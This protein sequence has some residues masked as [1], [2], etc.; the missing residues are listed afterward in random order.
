MKGLSDIELLDAYAAR[1]SEEAFRELV[2]RHVDFTYAV[3][4]RL[5]RNPPCEGRGSKDL[6]TMRQVERNQLVPARASFVLPKDAPEPKAEFLLYREH[7]F[8]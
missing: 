6:W 4:M 7:V 5:L 2:T 3:A 8:N 1:R